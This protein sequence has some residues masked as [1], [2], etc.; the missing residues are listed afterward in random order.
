MFQENID[1]KRQNML[2]CSQYFSKPV[3]KRG[4]KAIGAEPEA[5]LASCRVAGSTLLLHAAFLLLP[6][7]RKPTLSHGLD[8]ATTAV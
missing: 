7:L 4:R 8:G 6:L 5:Q 2:T 1:K 3:A